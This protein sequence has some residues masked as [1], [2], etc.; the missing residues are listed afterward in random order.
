MPLTSEWNWHLITLLLDLNYLV[1]FF[2]FPPC[3]GEIA[4]R[5]KT[6]V[7]KL[8]QELQTSG[9]R[10]Y[11]KTLRV[12]NKGLEQP[13]DQGILMPFNSSYREQ[14]VPIKPS[15]LQPL[16]VQPRVQ[17]SPASLNICV[18]D[19]FPRHA[20]FSISPML[21]NKHSQIHPVTSYQMKLRVWGEL[22][23]KQRPEIT[24]LVKHWTLC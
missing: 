19:W 18:L 17:L 2:S 10:I 5:S 4:H 23:L 3:R 12:S 20:M 9:A 6:W 13:V 15:P 8:S 14:W 16:L 24:W 11:R 22:S 1:N 21:N 7:A